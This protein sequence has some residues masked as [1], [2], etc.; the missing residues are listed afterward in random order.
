MHLDCDEFEVAVE[1]EKFRDEAL[2]ATIKE[3]GYAARVVPASQ[4]DLRGRS[5]QK[6]PVVPSPGAGR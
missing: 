1:A 4:G 2:I 3:A 5:P 6:A